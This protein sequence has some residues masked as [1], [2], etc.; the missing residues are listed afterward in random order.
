MTS[1]AIGWLT[2]TIFLLTSIALPLVTVAEEQDS[3]SKT[4]IG[5]R[6]PDLFYGGQ[7]LQAGNAEKGIR[8]THRG[9]AAAVGK[10]EKQAALNN[11]CAG[12]LMLEQWQTAL[13]YCNRAIE[14]SPDNWRSLSNRAF[15]YVKL[16]RYEDAAADLDKGQEIAPQSRSLK[17]VRGLFL[18]ATEPVSP[19]IEVDDRRHSVDKK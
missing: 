9:L 2:L 13:G 5:P 8:L 7:E 12:Y 17:E 19:S 18:D 15:A 3:Q 1:M 14:L 11:L 16:E 4:V 6:N 10:R